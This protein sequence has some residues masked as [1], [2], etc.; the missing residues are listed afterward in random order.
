M[1][2]KST[3]RMKGGDMV[4]VFQEGS[5]SNAPAKIY[6]TGEDAREHSKEEIIHELKQ[7]MK[8]SGGLSKGT[9][10][11]MTAIITALALRL[12]VSYYIALGLATMVGAISA[13]AVHKLTGYG[14]K[15]KSNNN[16]YTGSYAGLNPRMKG[17]Q[18][19]HQ[20]GTYIPRGFMPDLPESVQVGKTI[21]RQPIMK[22]G[23][24][25]GFPNS[26]VSGGI[27]FN[28]AAIIR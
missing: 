18:D 2:R 27:N 12:G 25:L 26:G 20:G 16:P 6:Y 22:G 5:N 3:K 10:A 9:G 1:P 21:T 14:R 15:V 24:I 8:E 11:T 7:V 4:I 17:G 28:P 23:A 19:S 13:T